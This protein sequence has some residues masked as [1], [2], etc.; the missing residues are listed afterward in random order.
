MT[1]L[2]PHDNP[3]ACAMIAKQLGGNLPHITKNYPLLYDALKAINCVNKHQLAVALGTVAVENPSFDVIKERGGP[4]YYRKMYWD[5]KRVAKM[6]GNTSAEDAVKYCGR[7]LIQLT[8]RFNYT[9]YGKQIGV[10]LVNNPDRALEPRIGCELFA[11]YFKDHGL[12]V[13][14]NNYA[15]ASGMPKETAL[16]K[17]RKLVNGGLNHYDRFKH[18]VEAFVKLQDA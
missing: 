6:L 11:A 13:W 10:D 16:Q 12:D 17:C 2:N 4:A 15:N 18:H 7:G 3:Q 1:S 9:K 5:N 14:S 8:G